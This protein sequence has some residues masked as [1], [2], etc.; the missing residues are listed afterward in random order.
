MRYILPLA[1][2]FSVFFVSCGGNEEF[3]IPDTLKEKRALLKTKNTEIN[4]LKQQLR[5]LE[6]QATK[7]QTLVDDEDPAVIKTTLVSTMPVKKVDFERFTQVQGTVQSDD[8]AI[9]T[10]ET[11]GR[12]TKLTVK[13]GDYVKKGKL[14]ATLDLESMDKQ[15]AEVQTALGLAN[16]VYER[17]KRLWDQNIGSEIQFLQ[18]QN[19]KERLEKSLETIRFQQTKG[20]VYAPISGTVEMVMTKQGEIAS[21]G[22]PIVQILNTSKIKVVAEAPETLLN[23]VKRG[24]QIRIEFPALDKEVTAPISLIGRT[25]NPGN[26]TFAVEANLNNR[27]G[28]LKPNLLAIIHIKDFSQKEV[29]TLPLGMI[30]QEIGGKKYVMVVGPENKAK[31]AYVK[32]GESYQGQVII[33]EGLTEK[34]VLVDKGARGLNEGDVLKIE[35]I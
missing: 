2:L 20:N 11:P 9:A 30:Q 34:S 27:D 12:I 13:E 4:T 5:A 33:E 16:E 22:M 26:R 15:I 17:Q 25:I 8:T 6:D 29:I 18:A 1:L 21:P 19:N 24:Q 7:L 3:V 23:A 32:T 10:S 35:N 28:S 14:I 31:K